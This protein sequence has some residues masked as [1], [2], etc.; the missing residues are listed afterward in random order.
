MKK[1]SIALLALAAALAIAPAALADTYNFNFTGN[2]ASYSTGVTY[3]GSITLEGAFTTSVPNGSNGG[4]VIT[5]FTGTYADPQDGVSGEISL[6]PGYGTYESYLVSADGSWNYDNLYYPGANAPNT[7]GGQFD[8]QGLLWYVGPSSNPDEWEVNF[9]A[10]TSTTYELVE[11]LTGSG[12]DYLNAS[13]GIGITDPSNPG[14]PS[15]QGPQ[16]TPAPEPSSLLL[17]G[18]GLLGLSLAALRKSKA[19]RP[20]S[21]M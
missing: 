3:P 10:G 11:S 17:L 13:N 1:F 20:G 8:L 12:Q 6:Y 16:I 18:S 15:D 5:S 4:T 2:I 9:W 19:S 21:R 7:T 14:N